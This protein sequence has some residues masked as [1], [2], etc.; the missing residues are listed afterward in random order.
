MNE[1]LAVYFTVDTAPPAITIA[2]PTNTTYRTT[3]LNLNFTAVDSLS[4]VAWTGYSL[5]AGPNV[6]SGN[7]TLYDN[8]NGPHR[9][10][11]YAN[12]SLG[13]TNSST[14]YFTIKAPVII[15]NLWTNQPSYSPG[16]QVTI[17]A[18][19]TNLDNVTHE[20]LKVN[21]LVW[22]PVGVLVHNST[23]NVP[24][25]DPGVTKKVYTKFTLSSSAPD[26]NYTVKARLFD[27]T[28]S[29]DIKW[30]SFQVT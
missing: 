29:Y 6:T 24:R 4:G 27:P 8:D 2:S 16:E 3:Y 7:T 23:K 19:V 25:V 17:N 13:N 21:F 30:S 28:K 5:D 20:G 10:T 1:T 12:D 18:N 26:G 22:D 14:V 15:K 11:V 9:I